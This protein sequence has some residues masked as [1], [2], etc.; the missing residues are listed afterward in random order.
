M[1]EFSDVGL[2]LISLYKSLSIRS[3]MWYSNVLYGKVEDFKS[4]MF[5]SGEFPWNLKI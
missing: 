1:S 4:L 2:L 3:S 5:D